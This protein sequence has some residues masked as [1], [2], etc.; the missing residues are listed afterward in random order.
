MSRLFDPDFVYPSDEM[1]PYVDLEGTVIGVSEFGSVKVAVPEHGEFTGYNEA[2]FEKI[3]AK[4]GDKV[5]IR[6]YDAGG[7]WY[8]DNKIV[9]WTRAG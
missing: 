4:A 2:M 3:Q 8:P 9:S 1:G 5:T 6:V 7:G